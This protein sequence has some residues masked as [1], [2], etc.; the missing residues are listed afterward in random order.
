MAQWVRRTGR[1]ASADSLRESMRKFPTKSG[2]LPDYQG[3]EELP[4]RRIL[5]LGDVILG[6]SG[7]A[8]EEVV[9]LPVLGTCRTSAFILRL[10]AEGLVKKEIADALNISVTANT[11]AVAKALREKL[12]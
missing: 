4:R 7:K 2:I 5:A 9:K 10:M 12:I 6:V 11:G 3:R 1:P 8:E